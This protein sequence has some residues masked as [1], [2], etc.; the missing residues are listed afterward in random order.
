MMTEQ[1]GATVRRSGRR[2]AGAGIALAAAAL[3]VAGCSQAL[4]VGPTPAAQHHLA[5]AIVLQIVQ[6]RPSTPAGSCPAGYARLPKAAEQSPGTG[7][8]YRRIGKPLSITS[9]AVTYLQQPA[10]NQQPANYGLGIKVSAA[11]K[12]A[13]LAITTKAYHSQDLIAIIAVGKTWAV[14]DWAGPFTG[15]FE[16]PAQNAK[17]ALQ[18]QRTLI[19]S[20]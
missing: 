20:A 19:P 2:P 7:Q 11:D 12:G 17:Q 16:I 5:S 1:G 3:T 18:F 15:Q 10:A 14:H 8:C 13:L 6:G 4:P 9:A